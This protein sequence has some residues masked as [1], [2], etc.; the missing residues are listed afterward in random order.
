MSNDV[1]GR[2]LAKRAED[3]GRHPGFT[4]LR[5]A[6]TGTL[7]VLACIAL[8]GLLTTGSVFF[9]AAAAKRTISAR[10]ATQVYT[11]ENA[12]AQIAFFHDTCQQAVAQQQIVA[13]NQ[14]RYDADLKAS[15][16]PDPIRQQQAE[17]QLAQ[18][19]QDVAG[20][21]N[22]LASTVAAYNS[23][24]AQSTANVFKGSNLPER[25]SVNDSISCG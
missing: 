24:S 15:R 12:I 14:A 25:L 13:N 5:W 22:V 10:V 1:L 3:A 8:V 11:P 19:Q 7:I 9:R 16:S 20:A 18:D 23:R 2:R 21:R 17:T 4:L 6:L